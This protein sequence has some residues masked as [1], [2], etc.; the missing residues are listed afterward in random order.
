MIESNE[1][2]FRC[3]ASGSDGNCYYL[4]TRNKGI[5]ID[6]GIALRNIERDL[7]EMSLNISKQIIGVLV[8]HDHADHIRSVGKLSEKYNLPVYATRLV[9]EGMERNPGLQRKLR[10]NKQFFEVGKQWL[11]GD[12]VIDSC[13]V[14]HDSTQCVAFHIQTHDQHFVLI[15]DCG[16]PN[17][18]IASFIRQANHIVIEANHD[19]DI[20]LKGSYPSFL[21]E[22]ILS[23]I[24]HQSNHTCGR[25]LSENYHRGLRNIFLCHLSEENNRPVVAHDTIT[26]YL[27]GLGLIENHDFSLRVLDRLTPSQV[28][29][30]DEHVIPQ[31]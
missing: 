15:T 21:K 24:G 11:L 9:H 19:E 22:R 26:Q 25:L 31:E 8:T 12:M 14:S 6:A 1:L 10:E 23:D 7:H 30:L 28:F 18:T 3:L 2:I 29:V 13:V 20:L 27:Q 5:L 16:M 4:G 17:E